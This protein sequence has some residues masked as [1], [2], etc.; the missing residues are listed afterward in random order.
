MCNTSPV[1]L[2]TME[3][4]L[5][6]WDKGLH[7]LRLEG[8]PLPSWPMPHLRCRFSELLLS[9]KGLFG[10]PGSGVPARSWSLQSSWSVPHLSLDFM[11]SCWESRDTMSEGELITPESSVVSSEAKQLLT[12]TVSSASNGT[13]GAPSTLQGPPGPMDRLTGRDTQGEVSH[14]ASELPRPDSPETASVMGATFSLK[15]QHIFN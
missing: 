12:D 9:H 6:H 5:A 4:W 13:G 2:L 14:R 7:P 10:G 15:N 1:R 3:P 11:L 8:T